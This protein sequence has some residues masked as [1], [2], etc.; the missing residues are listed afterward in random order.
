MGAVGSQTLVTVQ[1]TM[2]CPMPQRRE[3]VH[4]RMSIA[5]LPFKSEAVHGRKRIV[6]SGSV[7]VPRSSSTA[8]YPTM[9]RLC[10]TKYSEA[11]HII[12]RTTHFPR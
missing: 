2:C 12:N 9:V 7:A 11:P 8:H 1:K 10:T 6:H 4:R 5:P 3:A